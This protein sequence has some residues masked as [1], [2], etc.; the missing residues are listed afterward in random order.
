MKWF[1]RNEIREAEGEVIIDDPV[2]KALIEKDDIDK[3]KALNI[4]SVYGCVEAITNTIAS[5]PI[6]LYIESENET[7]E[8]KDD[9]R[10]K[11]LN[12]ET[13]DLLDA[14]QAKKAMLRDYLLDG[15]GYMYINKLGNKVE[16]LH[17][18]ESQCVNATSNNDPIFKKIDIRVMGVP[19][20]DFNFVALTRNTVDGFTGNGI[21][22]ENQLI[23]SV[24]YNSLKYENVLVK[25]GGNKK[26]FLKS[27]NK[28]TQEIID[29]L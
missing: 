11:L 20:R 7:K 1:K 12:D 21:I 18:I 23:L 15:N 10:L 8:I 9:Y 22:N 19:Y 29:N 27:K 3:E 16:S 26:G 17:Y 6:K 14:Y 13:G 2:L 4:P 5:M 25:T 28:L 24:A